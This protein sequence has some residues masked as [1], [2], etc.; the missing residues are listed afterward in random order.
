MRVLRHQLRHAVVGAAGL[1]HVLACCVGF[2]RRGGDRQ[3]LL[4]FGPEA[5]RD[6]ESLVEVDQHGDVPHPLADVLEPG[7]DGHHAV[8]VGARVDVVEDVDLA[9]GRGVRL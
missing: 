1:V 7:R 2:D 3:H 6:A 4:I 8:E 5:I 9:H